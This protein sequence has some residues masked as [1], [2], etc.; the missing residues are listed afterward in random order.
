MKFYT[1]SF[2][3]IIN[4]AAILSWYNHDQLEEEGGE[5]TGR[6]N[7]GRSGGWQTQRKNGERSILV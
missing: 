1:I 2:Q 5:R 7:R 4:I 3:N 6:T